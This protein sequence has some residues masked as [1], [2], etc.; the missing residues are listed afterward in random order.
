MIKENSLSA[1]L[2]SIEAWF[3]L[4]KQASNAVFR[5][6]RRIAKALEEKRF[7]KVKSLCYLLTHSFYG[8]VHAIMKA[9]TN[10]GSKTAGVDKQKWTTAKDLQNAIPKLN[11]R[12]Y[13]PQPLRR[14][15]ILKKN[16]KTRP[17]SI[18]T[19]LDRAMQALYYTAYEPIAYKNADV[20]SFGFRTKHSCADAIEQCFKNLAQ[21]TC[22]TKIYDADISGCFDNI[23]HQWIL[24]KNNL[25]LLDKTMI[26]KWLQCGYIFN[27]QFLNT[28]KG[29]PQ[30]GIIS[31]LLANMVLDGLQEKIRQT[32]KLR[33]G[34]NFVRYAD[35]FIITSPN[36][37]IIETR[38]KP[39]VKEFLS[40]R[41]LSI[42]EEKTRTA[43]IYKGF[44][45]LSFNIRKYRNGKLL[46][47]PAKKAVVS[48]FGKVREKLR[49]H[50]ATTIKDLISDLNPVLRGW[51]NYFRHVVSKQVFNKADHVIRQMIFKWAERRHPTKRRGW[52]WKTYFTSGRV[53]GFLSTKIFDPKKQKNKIF[54]LYSLCYTPIVRY[55]KIKAG[56]NPFLKEYDKY[57]ADRNK[58][59]I[60][61]KKS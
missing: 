37:E 20:Y 32:V 43:D 49:K 61:Q 35:D 13:K 6:Q 8:K 33:R 16:G 12:T 50:R 24:D 47:K 5:L 53:R 45:F 60:T 7:N 27:R 23:N 18:P 51:A 3:S 10:K 1:A 34:V 58:Q 4:W 48:L 21:K 2:N 38:I 40:E 41:G 9:K 52:I 54:C 31:P 57:F 42:S 28:E 14:I 11:R 46:I 59:R 44:D 29:T 30:G 25:K 36:E 15:H 56:A 26:R 19:M 17:L 39:A 22:S 55:V